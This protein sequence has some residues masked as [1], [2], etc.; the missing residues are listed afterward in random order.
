MA[1]KLGSRDL[2]GALIERLSSNYGCGHGEAP[3]NNGA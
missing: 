1:K 3:A 2:N